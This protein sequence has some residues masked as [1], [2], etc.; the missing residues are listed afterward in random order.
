VAEEPR[1]PFVPD[2]VSGA[3]GP[4][5]FCRRI[6]RVSHRRDPD[7]GEFRAIR[8]PR[9]LRCYVPTVTSVIRVTHVVG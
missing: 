3:F 7:S 4:G 1:Q 9:V 5:E 8:G 6:R 2:I